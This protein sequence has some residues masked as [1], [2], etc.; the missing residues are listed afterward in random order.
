MSLITITQNM[1]CPGEKIAGI[2]ASSLDLELY[3]DVRLQQTVQAMGTGHA[4]LEHFD[5]KAPGF[6]DRLISSK[7]DVYLDLME[8]AIYE[9]AKNGE[10]VIIGH[11][12]QFLLR[13]FSC[14]LHVLVYA[15]P[16]TRIEYLVEI[17]GLG[18]KVARRLIQ[19]SDDNQAGFFRYAF[20]R[21]WNDLSLFD[22]VV[23]VEKMTQQSVA[24]LI[25]KAARNQEVKTC[26]LTAI[27]AMD[28]LSLTKKVEAEIINN[29]FSPL[30]I[31]VSVPEK[32]V[33]LIRGLTESDGELNRLKE[34][35]A[36]VDAVEKVRCEVSV[37]P[38]SLI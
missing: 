38:Q 30:Y 11:G 28:R 8:A 7:P 35:V 19:K 31:H 25:V 27:D 13:D 20:E 10:G 4:D 21:E 33:A 34:I 23:S 17:R 32:G 22:L 3:D 14:A 26:S 6:F 29:G 18:P 36:A 37:R 9:V 12:G 1:G 5:Q 15:E 2:V 24:G 16:S